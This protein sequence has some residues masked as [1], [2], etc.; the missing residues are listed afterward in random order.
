M[1]EITLQEVA[2][3]WNGDR[4]RGYH[5]RRDR[6]V[7]AEAVFERSA[8]TKGKRDTEIGKVA[9]IE[10]PEGHTFTVDIRGLTDDDAAH[11]WGSGGE[12]LDAADVVREAV[13]EKFQRRDVDGVDV[14]HDGRI[15]D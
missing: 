15:D 11:M 6:T 5:A 7:E 9:R 2:V 12:D 3:D 1:K 10:F 14:T 8:T 13:A 4:V